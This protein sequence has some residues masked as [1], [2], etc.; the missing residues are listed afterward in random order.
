MQTLLI[1]HLGFFRQPAT[2]G[3]L[4]ESASN[5]EAS[6][7]ALLSLAALPSVHVKL[8]AF[9]RLS[10][11]PPPHADLAPRLAELLGNFGAERILCAPPRR[12]GRRAP[13]R[14]AEVG[15]EA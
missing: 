11:E 2:G 14:I 8:S 4:H 7:Q 12:R 1:D 10:S 15:E 9:F 6:W 5:D 3:L 13:H